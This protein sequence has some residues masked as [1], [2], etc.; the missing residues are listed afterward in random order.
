MDEDSYSAAE[1]HRYGNK[2]WGRQGKCKKCILIQG[3]AY[4]VCSIDTMHAAT[5]PGLVQ[6]A[7]IILTEPL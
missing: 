1:Y 5:A 4:T 6:K 2:N 3:M 7:H